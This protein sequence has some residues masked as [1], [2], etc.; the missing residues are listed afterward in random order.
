MRAVGDAEVAEAG[1]AF[2]Y[3]RQ[4]LVLDIAIIIIFIIITATHRDIPASLDVD[5]LKQRAVPG[6]IVQSFVRDVQ[7]PLQRIVCGIVSM[8]FN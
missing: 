6:E 1:A 7:T 4:P 8:N 3:G 5:I 2:A